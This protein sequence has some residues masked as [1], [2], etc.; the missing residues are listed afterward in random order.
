[1]EAIILAFAPCHIEGSSIKNRHVIAITIDTGI[2]PPHPRAAAIVRQAKPPFPGQSALPMLL[3]LERL[4][5][6]ER[7]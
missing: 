7:W 6:K 5:K 1:M 2:A 3:G 4:I